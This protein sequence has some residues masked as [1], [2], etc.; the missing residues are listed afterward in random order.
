M[1][2]KNPP[3]QHLMMRKTS[4]EIADLLERGL[5]GQLTQE[6]AGRV[7]NGNGSSCLMDIETHIRVTG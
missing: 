3:M 5:S 4:D 1:G 2:K 7:V 6:L